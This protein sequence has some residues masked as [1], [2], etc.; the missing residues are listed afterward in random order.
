MKPSGR[1]ATADKTGQK[2]QAQTKQSSFSRSHLEST[3]FW[4]NRA[5]CRVYQAE[6][7]P[8]SCE[9][10]GRTW[11]GIL[12]QLDA[13]CGLQDRQNWILFRVSECA[14]RNAPWNFFIVKIHCFFGTVPQRSQTSSG[15]GPDRCYSVR[16]LGAC[17]LIAPNLALPPFNLSFCTS[18]I[19]G[20]S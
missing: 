11:A 3:S 4:R 20:K 18:Y 12:D 5:S 2:C 14:P 8:V 15:F 10:M 17:L 13:A 19:F 16:F 6:K 7:V 1:G 9:L